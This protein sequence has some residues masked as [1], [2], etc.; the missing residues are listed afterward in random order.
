MYQFSFH[1]NEPLRRNSSNETCYSRVKFHF[2]KHME[3]NLV[4]KASQ[5]H[6]MIVKSA[7]RAIF[8]PLLSTNDEMSADYFVRQMAAFIPVLMAGTFN[9]KFIFIFYHNLSN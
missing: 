7:Y 4:S 3:S 1:V 6:T 2:E 9:Q 8:I 5:L